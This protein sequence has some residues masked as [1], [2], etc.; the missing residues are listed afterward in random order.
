MVVVAAGGVL[1]VCRW[2]AGG[3]PVVCRWCAGGVP[4]VCQWW[5]GS[6]LVVANICAADRAIQ[7]DGISK[8]MNF[9]VIGCC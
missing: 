8:D 1:V 6:K 7:Y 3:V 5:S 9:Y 2:C 4:V